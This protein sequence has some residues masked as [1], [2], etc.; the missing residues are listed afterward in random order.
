MT[1]HPQKGKLFK[2]KHGY[3]PNSSS[4]GSL[5]YALPVSMIAVTG[6]FAVVSALILTAFAEKLQGKSEDLGRDTG[7]MNP[8]TK[9]KTPDDTLS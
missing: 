2:V 7:G 4:M 6:G 8:G 5:I 3:N 9:G 1:Q